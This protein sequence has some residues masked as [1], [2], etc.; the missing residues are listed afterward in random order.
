MN[1]YLVRWFRNGNSG[2]MV[3]TATNGLAA[4][5]MVRNIVGPGCCISST[6]MVF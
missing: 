2:E 4:A 1:K 5:D 3:M 6:V